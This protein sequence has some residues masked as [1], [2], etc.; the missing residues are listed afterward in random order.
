MAGAMVALRRAAAAAGQAED[1]QGEAAALIEAVDCALQAGHF[2]PADTLIGALRNLLPGLD[3]AGAARS[4]L[5][6]RVREAGVAYLTGRLDTADSLYGAA[7]SAAAAAGCT[8]EA[9]DALNGRGSTGSRQ[10]RVEASRRDYAAALD[11]ARR[12]GDRDRQAKILLNL[13]YDETQARDFAAAA[14][15]L[16]EARELITTCGRVRMLGR[17]HTG[18]GALAEGRGDRDGAVRHFRDACRAFA[19]SGDLGGELGARQWLAYNLMMAGH[20]SEAVGHYERGLAI[21]DTLASPQVLNWVLAGLALTNHRLGH[22]ERAETFYLRAMAVNEQLGDRM[23]VAWCRHSLG[24]LEVLRGNY[25]EALVH[26]L[27]ALDICTGL[28]D[29]EGMGEARVA[30]A[31]VHFRLGDWER[32]L[33]EFEAA[34]AIARE[35]GLEELLQSAVTGLSVVC[36]A[37]GQPARARRYCE[38]GLAIARRWGDS[39]AVIWALVELAELSL[40]GGDPAAARAHLAEAESRLWPRGPHV[41]RARTRLAQARCADDPGAAV[42]LARA[43]LTQAE[44]GGLPEQEWTCLTELGVLQLAA[45]DSTAALASQARAI[46]VIESLRRN[47]GSDELRRHMLRPALVPYERIVAL[48]AA[49]GAPGDLPLAFAYAERS[50]ARILA[51]RLRSALAGEAAAPLGDAARDLL[52]SI[53]HCQDR[54]QDP[55]LPDSVRT[56]LRHRVAMHENEF[57]MLELRAAGGA[58]RPSAFPLVPPEPERLLSLPRAGEQVVAY[59]LGREAS[60]LFHVAAG[61]VSAHALPAGNEIESLVRRYLALRDAPEA[62]PGQIATAS[63]RLHTLLLAPALA[64]GPC[65]DPLVIV[66]DGL[67]HRLP[68]AALADEAGTLA[69][70]CRSFTVPSLQTLDYL[71][72]RES[73]R[74][75]GQGEATVPVV[76]VGY[77]GPDESPRLHPWQDR[78]FAP[79]RQADDEARQVAALFRGAIL[80]TGSAAGERALV[81]APLRRA[82]ILHLAAHGDAD[83]RDVRRSFV[84]LGRGEHG[85]DGLLQWS[86]AAAL[87]LG[88]SLVTL[89]SC[90]SARGPLAVGEGVTG[91]TQAFLFAGSTCVLAAQ[92]DVGDAF[93]REFML[94][95]YRH[96]RAGDTAAGALRRAQLAAAADDTAG[97]GGWADFVLVGDGSVT[98]PA[99]AAAGGVRPYVLVLAGLVLAAAVTTAALRR[100]RA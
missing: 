25:R 57:L 98:M 44:A 68:F 45:G 85:A 28:G 7:A 70:R 96:L 42:E 48:L 88:T 10:R 59:F 92:T 39:N 67:L 27:A 21:T 83:D 29:H 62:T 40:G 11:L 18:L 90:R 76:A 63:H 99:A 17:V 65:P 91:L 50:R 79:L 41:L 15:H 77:G 37:A 81:A 72:R 54:L 19:A 2:A 23:S 64:A 53:G 87:D 31:D 94:S 33:D 80:L 20:Y 93:S 61:G 95:F 100:A 71:R 35:Q 55:D 89:A 69:S 86:E 56:D 9:C 12:L 51:N 75:A 97:R 43:A 52:S 36:S 24:L 60:W 32:A 47:V 13:A 1:P 3:A 14:A 26:N 49:R 74:R 58:D 82:G 34:V 6:V 8:A 73:R 30:L 16:A 78:P 4:G 66:P 84:L 46:D 38:E 5:A 22:L